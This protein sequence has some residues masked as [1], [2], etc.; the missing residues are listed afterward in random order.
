M[1][2]AFDFKSLSPIVIN[3]HIGATPPAE[4]II[5]HLLY[6]IMEIWHISSD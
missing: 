2:I 1:I 4:S 3:S 6:S 5:L